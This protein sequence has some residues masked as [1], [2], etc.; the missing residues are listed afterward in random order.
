MKKTATKKT[1]AS[2]AKAPGSRSNGKGNGASF[3]TSVADLLAQAQAMKT[4][5]DALGLASLTEEERLHSPGKLRTKEGDAM[6][7]ILDTVDGFPQVFGAL[8]DKDG[9]ADPNVVETAPARAALARVQTLGPVAAVLESVLTRVSDDVL[10]SAATAKE[11]TVPAYAIGKVNAA[12]NP[13]VR[14]TLAGAI[15]FYAKTAR[16]AKPVKPAKPTK[17]A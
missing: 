1:K 10:A 8:A 2:G 3:E 12:S 17:P 14:K 15:N 9:G 13:K 16:H 6:T 5:L 11:V 4:S 7:A